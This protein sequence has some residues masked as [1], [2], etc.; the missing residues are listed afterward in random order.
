MRVGIT[1]AN[2]IVGRAYVRHAVGLGHQVTEFVR[3][4]DVRKEVQ[5]LLGS[6]FDLD[7]FA[8]LDCVIHLAWDRSR[9]QQRSQT[10]NLEGASRLVDACKRHHVYPHFLSTMSAYANPQSHYGYTKNQVENIFGGGGGTYVRAGLI[11]G[12]EMTPMLRSIRQIS[13]LP[14]ICPHLTPTSL[15]FHSFEDALISASLSMCERKLSTSESGDVVADKPVS[16]EEIQHEFNSLQRRFHMSVPSKIVYEC[17]RMLESVRIPLPFRSDSL[18]S[19]LGSSGLV[20]PNLVKSDVTYG[21]L[22][23]NADFFEWLRSTN[24]TS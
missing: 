7:I 14:L 4:P 2:S 18:A 9:D 5:L 8:D 16:L 21:V 17:S 19:F 20:I 3:V 22:P 1:G 15:L 24:L 13:S 23:G 6:D 10:A 11:W 12:G